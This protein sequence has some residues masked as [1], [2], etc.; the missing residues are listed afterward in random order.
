MRRTE[1]TKD[2]AITEAHVMQNVTGVCFMVAIVLLLVLGAGG[3]K[4]G[5][6]EV[7][8]SGRKST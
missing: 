4:T 6:V 5:V 8:V 1:T 7:R 3:I 2:V